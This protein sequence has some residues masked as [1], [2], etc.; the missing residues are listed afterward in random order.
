[1]VFMRVLPQTFKISCENVQMTH[2]HDLPYPPEWDSQGKK[3]GSPYYRPGTFLES[4]SREDKLALFNRRITTRALAQK[5]E[6]AECYVS[7]LFPGKIKGNSR[8]KSVLLAARREYRKVVA[9]KVL[10]GEL[11]LQTAAA[12]LHIHERTMRRALKS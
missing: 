7:Q 11:A 6:V 1:M 8:S 9:A 4:V 2:E 10:K 5:Y 12:E 3:P